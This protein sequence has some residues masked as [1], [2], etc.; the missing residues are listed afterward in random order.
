MTTE[1]KNGGWL[2]SDIINGYL[3]SRYYIGYTKKEAISQ[4]KNDIKKLRG[5]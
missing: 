3:E 1:I 2:I 5:K 4:F